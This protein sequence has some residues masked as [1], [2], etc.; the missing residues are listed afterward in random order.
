MA[1]TPTAEPLVSIIMCAYNAGHF[2]PPAIRSAL[3]QTYGNIELLV[4][5]DGSTD[6][7]VEAARQQTS[8]SRIRW[9]HQENAGK[10]A[11]M[12]LA[13]QHAEGDF[14]AL[15][16][17]D[18]LSRPRRIERL[19]TAMQ[20]HPDVA[21]VFSGHDLI[22]DGRHMAET[23]RAKSTEECRRDI[24]R[25]AMPAHDPTAMYR[26]SL[27]RDFEY[28]VTLRIGEGY[29]YILRVGEQY[30][31]IVVGECLYSYRIHWESLCRANPVQRQSLMRKAQAK[32]CERRG[33]CPEE[34]IASLQDGQVSSRNSQLDNGLAAHFA[35]SVQDL[36]N[37]GQ[38]IAS[39]RTGFQCARLHP[40][41]F[42]YLKPLIYSVSPNWVRSR[43]RSYRS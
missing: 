37:R 18:D 31:M 35:H 6:D 22:L 25:M 33:I 14:Y 41:D 40:F 28:D 16:D 20:E 36:R 43:V 19:V 10:P 24:E 8:D 1:N 27:V 7:S 26:M 32:T 21:A 38:L 30:P 42:Q 12:N 4:V 39:I 13:L 5:D 3:E 23:S 9:F 11:A 29:D 2:L 34:W 17:A 15:Q